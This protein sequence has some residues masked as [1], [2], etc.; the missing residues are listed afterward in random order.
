[1]RLLAP[2]KVNL[3]LE[4]FPPNRSGYHPLRSWAVSVDWQDE[5]IAEW[6]E[7]DDEF[8]VNG[9]TDEVPDD[10]SNL[11]WRAVELAR[12]RAGKDRPLRMALTK[13]I[14]AGAGLAG[15]ST[16]G[17]AA[18]VAL[19][20]LMRTDAAWER[21]PLL[22]ADVR[23]CL[24]GGSQV[25][26]GIGERLTPHPSP[27][28]LVLGIV[29]PPFHLA[30]AEV[31]RTWDRLGGPSGEVVPDRRLPPSLRDGIPLRNDLFPAAIRV[32][33][34]LDEWRSELEARWDRPVLLS[35]SGSALFAF[36][37]DADEAEDALRQA[38]PERRAARCA[39]PTPAG[40]SIAD[41]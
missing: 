16:D 24:R 17:A 36:F 4:V 23:F 3:S 39:A 28:D 29:V 15:G 10:E 14:P 22:G 30:T 25:V 37:A 11:V 32:A 27:P 9:R 13:H 21:A 20:Q 8:V 6:A 35:G 33:P 18:L 1:M 38:P 19:D 41:H 34:D 12:G 31:F 40:V 5:L 7:D 2:A 26:E